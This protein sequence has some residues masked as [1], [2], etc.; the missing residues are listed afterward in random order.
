MANPNDPLES[1]VH[2]TLR[3]TPAR[4]APVSLEQRVLAQIARRAALPWYRQSYRHWPAGARIGFLVTSAALAALALVLC[5]ALFRNGFGA[6]FSDWVA[7][8]KHQATSA[9]TFATATLSH[10][11]SSTVW[12]LAGAGIALLSMSLATVGL[13]AAAYRLLWKNS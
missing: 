4:R 7:Q 9:Q 3:A 1:F 8:L 12:W 11:P 2:A 13:G 5:Y 10:L 6:G